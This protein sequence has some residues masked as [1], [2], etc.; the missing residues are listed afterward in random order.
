M[1]IYRNIISI[2]MLRALILS[3]ILSHKIKISILLFLFYYLTHFYLAFEYEQDEYVLKNNR[4]CS[5]KLVIHLKLLHGI[6]AF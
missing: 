4:N 3:T 2:T 1:N 6:E 5:S